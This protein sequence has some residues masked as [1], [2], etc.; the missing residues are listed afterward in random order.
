MEL[1]VGCIADPGILLHRESGHA[2]AAEKDQYGRITE[3]SRIR[4]HHKGAVKNGIFHCPLSLA[5]G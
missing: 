1:L 3:V 4:R 2:S 5:D